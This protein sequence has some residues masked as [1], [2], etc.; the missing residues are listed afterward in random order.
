MAA[1]T[2]GLYALSFLRA[3]R[4]TA[5]ATPLTRLIV[6]SGLVLVLSSALPL[7]S[8]IALAT[9]THWAI[10]VAMS[11]WVTFILSCPTISFLLSLLASVWPRRSPIPYSLWLEL[12]LFFHFIFSRYERVVYGNMT[13]LECQ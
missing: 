13:Q 1:S 3:I 10:M 9:L 2:V 4:P 7:L 12:W 5:R 8:R 11:G 6:N